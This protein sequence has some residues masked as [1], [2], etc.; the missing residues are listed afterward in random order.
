MHNLLHHCCKL[1]DQGSIVSHLTNAEIIYKLPAWSSL[2]TATVVSIW[3]RKSGSVT[4]VLSQLLFYCCNETPWPEKLMESLCGIYS[5]RGSIMAGT[6]WFAE[7]EGVKSHLKPQT[8]S[9]VD[10]LEIERIFKQSKPTPYSVLTLESKSLKQCHQLGPRIQMSE[11]ERNIL[12]QTI[13][14]A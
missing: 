1:Q 5:C 8:G 7:A 4:V 3:N 10:K 9:R 6:T 13:T 12:I 2:F 11:P 14:H